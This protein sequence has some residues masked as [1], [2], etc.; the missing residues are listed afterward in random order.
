M[1][2]PE[3]DGVTILWV[4]DQPRNNDG[5]RAALEA[6]GADVVSA[7]TNDEALVK[8]NTRPFDLVISDIGRPPGEEEGSELGLRLWASRRKIPLIHY[9]GR[10]D[11]GAP[12]P[13]GSDGVTADPG[14]LL[15]MVRTAVGRG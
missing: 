2:E 9:I 7:L 13:V 11:P 6:L 1:A 8:A 12:P 5:E 4:D 15:R 3:L 14:E 10:V